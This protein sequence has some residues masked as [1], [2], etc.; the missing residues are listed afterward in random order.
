M[1][2]AILI[3]LISLLTVSVSIGQSGTGQLIRL[4]IDSPSLS[5]NIIGDPATKNIAVYLPPSYATSEKHYP[6]VYF[7]VGHDDN[8]NAFLNGVI[9]GFT[10]KTSMDN[11][12]NAGT[13]KEMIFVLLDGMNL[14]DGSFY[15]N[16]PVTGNWRDWVV[17]D[18]VSYIDNNYR[19]LPVRESRAITGHSMGGF[20]AVNIGMKNSETF[21]AVYSLSPGLFDFNG[22]KDQGMFASENTIRA[23]LTKF[24]EWKQM[25]KSEALAAFRTF[26]TQRRT[27][28]D[29]FT[30]FTYGYGAAFSPDPDAYPPF[31]KFPYYLENNVLKCDSTFLHNY[32]NGFGGIAEEVVEFKNNLLSLIDFT[33][34]YG[35]RDYFRWICRG[36][37]YMSQIL[38]DENIPHQ[39]VSFN[40]DHADQLRNRIEQ[41]MLPRLS[42]KFRFE[43]TPTGIED[44]K[45]MLNDFNLFQNYPNPFNPTT[46]IKY[47]IPT[48]VETGQLARQLTGAPS[49]QTTLKI[50]DMLGNEV[51]TLVNEQKEPGNYEVEFDGSQL[52]SGVYFY[53]IEI[54]SDKLTVDNAS[55]R[56]GKYFS[57]AK[58]LVLLK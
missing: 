10:V 7:L 15:E 18:V 55:H 4:S 21:G 22:L 48:S 27:S 44:R 12:I 9:Q 57:S 37:T 40:G 2:K 26:I 33:I 41:F 43:D 23:Y 29:W 8:I 32:E 46:T 49:L 52:S 45:T 28:G 34:D 14:L 20:G 31:L 35:T 50:Y 39:L 25:E 47:S 17:N 58:K 51:V 24:N 54:H 6:V 38:T 16:S 13:I 11:L 30:C 56:R 36:C 42:E 19:T 3:F 5:N 1:N 53:R